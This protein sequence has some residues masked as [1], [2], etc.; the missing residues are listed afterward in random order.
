MEVEQNC[1]TVKKQAGSQTK[2]KQP[3]PGSSRTNDLCALIRG[4]RRVEWLTAGLC[5]VVGG[6]I[7]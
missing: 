4:D 7:F 3:R 5:S 1:G 6:D 2:P